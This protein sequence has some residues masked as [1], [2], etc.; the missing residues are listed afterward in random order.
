MVFLVFSSEKKIV[1]CFDYAVEPYD[2]TSVASGSGISVQEAR[3]ILH[4]EF[5]GFLNS[6]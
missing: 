5:V 4:E 2:F 6:K 1:R 3:F